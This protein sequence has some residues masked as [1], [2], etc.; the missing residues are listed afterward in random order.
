MTESQPAGWYHA[1]GDPPETKRY[2]DGS[3]WIGEPT[4]MATG[5]TAAGSSNATT[6][7][8]IGARIID[9]LLLMVGALLP[10]GA[11]FANHA[12][13]D[14]FPDAEDPQFDTL[15]EDWIELQVETFELSP[16]VGA[17]AA[18]FV[19]WEI[20]WL[21]FAGGSPG[22]LLVGLR[23]QHAK[24]GDVGPGWVAAVLRNVLRLAFVVS[25][26]I[27]PVGWVILLAVIASVVMLFADSQGRTLVDR[28][29]STVVVD[30]KSI[31]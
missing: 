18:F 31:V 26:V 7:K 9:W 2:W 14:A 8:R 5:G 24:T 27:A 1:A 13:F 15:M 6:G 17:V 30:K 21:G 10:I 11:S 19:L 22:K 20:L 16:I 28:V 25:F 3:M 23:V 4:L 29:A 12:D